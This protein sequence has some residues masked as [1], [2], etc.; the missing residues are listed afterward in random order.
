MVLFYHV[1]EIL[2]LLYAEN[3]FLFTFFS[4]CYPY[5]GFT[6]CSPWSRSLMLGAQR[7]NTPEA[8]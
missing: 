8:N 6:G 7:A 5:S 1:S 3:L 2:E 4:V